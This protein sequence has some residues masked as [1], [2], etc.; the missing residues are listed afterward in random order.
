[1]VR[2]AAVLGALALPAM[3]SAF[4]GQIA[5]VQQQ[6]AQHIREADFFLNPS[7]FQLDNTNNAIS[8][9]W[10]EQL[11][12]NDLTH[13]RSLLQDYK[14]KFNEHEKLLIPLSTYR[15][16]L[17]TLL[18]AKKN[19]R[20]INR[21]KD[22]MNKLDI[23][24]QKVKAADNAVGVAFHKVIDERIRLIAA[25]RHTQ[26]TRPPRPSMTPLGI[27]AGLGLATYLARPKEVTFSGGSCRNF[28]P[29][30]SPRKC[31]GKEDPLTLDEI[32][33]NDGCCVLG[34]CYH[35]GPD[36]ML[37]KWLETRPGLNPPDNIKYP[38]L[39]KAAVMKACP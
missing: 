14:N 17:D 26:Q 12:D 39:T 1:M 23:A 21:E 9:N 35:G 15:N 4:G 36:G 29:T 8:K 2:N 7:L 10:R 6:A 27:G 37:A 25:A 28:Y 18:H 33:G 31:R 34:H 3:T 24:L 5:L 38:W 16:E 13:L 11:S 22:I 32:E 20:S 19:L 30:H